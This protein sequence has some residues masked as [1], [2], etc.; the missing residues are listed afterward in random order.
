MNKAHFLIWALSLTTATMT[1]HAETVVFKS[2]DPEGN[3][4]YGDEPSIDAIEFEVL[5]FETDKKSSIDA[6]TAS[7]E[8]IENMAAT[9]KR[10][11]DDRAAR[12]R[13]RHAAQQTAN[14]SPPYIVQQRDSEHA[15]HHRREPYYPRYAPLKRP[16]LPYYGYH[17]DSGLDVNLGYRSSR[18][19]GSLNL[20]SRT[21]GYFYKRHDRDRGH[22]YD[23]RVYNGYNDNF[24]HGKPHEQPPLR[25][26]RK[27]RAPSPTSI[28]ELR[29]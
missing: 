15:H 28:R 18:F 6:Q 29:H 17:P 10:L 20:G 13:A 2:T 19:R 11:Q 27:P 8:R 23:D 24:R 12:E 3:I 1:I 21:P 26:I 14:H 9:T 16:H 25:E 7:K 5:K 22:Y 4:S